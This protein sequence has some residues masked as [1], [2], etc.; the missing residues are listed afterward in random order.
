[1]NKEIQPSHEVF[2]DTMVKKQEQQDQKIQDQSKE[3]AGLQQSLQAVPDYSKDIQ[4]IRTGQ[5]EIKATLTNLQFPTDKMLAF[6]QKLD[7]GINLLRNPVENKITHQHHVSKIIW[8]T[9]GLFLVLCLVCSAWLKTASTLDQ[10]KAG[11]TKYRYL[12][13]K[14][15]IALLPFLFQLDS[16][17]RS[18]YPMKDSV[19]QWEE[20][21]QKAIEL[22]RQLQQKQGEGEELKKKVE[23]VESQNKAR[24]RK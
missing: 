16:L 18:S 8:I 7:L 13:L 5:E 4:Q 11:D 3:I 1:M 10:Y 21:I 17:Y 12:K 14:S 24:K 19:I 20:D 2:M 6:S 15:N 9:A 22:N 23:E